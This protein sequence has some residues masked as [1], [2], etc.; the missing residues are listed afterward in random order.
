MSF[1]IMSQGSPRYDPIGI[2]ILD[3]QAVAGGLACLASSEEGVDTAKQVAEG[4]GPNRQKEPPGQQA[5]LSPWEL[6]IVGVVD[7]HRCE[8][9][10][11]GP[12]RVLVEGI[13]VADPP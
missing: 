6:I 1:G 9:A 2:G 7:R 8:C 5:G 12:I 13:C 3:W 10:I 4:Y 11:A